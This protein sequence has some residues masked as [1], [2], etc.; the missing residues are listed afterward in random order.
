MTLHAPN[1][2]ASVEANAPAALRPSSAPA[3]ASFGQR[4][5]RGDCK[6][7]RAYQAFEPRR[8][9]GFAAE[10]CRRPRCCQRNDDEPGRAG[11][12]EDQAEQ[13]EP[14]RLVRRARIYELREEGEEEQSHLGI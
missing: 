13:Y 10:A 1:N 2:T 4:E 9:A 6:Q 8:N 14:E 5:P 7:R 12:G 3:L 11:R